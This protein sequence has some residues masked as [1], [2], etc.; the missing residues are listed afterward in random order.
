DGHALRLDADLDLAEAGAFFDVDDRHRVVVFVGDVEDLAGS[1][2]GEQFGI[3]AGGQGIDHLLLRN[4]DDLNAVVIADGDEH[5]LSVPRELDAARPLADL[6]G[7][8]DGPTVRIDDG[9]GVALLV[10]HI[11]DE[12]RGGDHRREADGHYGKQAM[13]PTKQYKL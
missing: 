13:T 12:G 3:R 10:G 8:G 1:I 4:I 7:L 11:G 2:E 5:K 9:Y 6:D